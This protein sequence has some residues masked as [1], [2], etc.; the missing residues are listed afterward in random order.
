MNAKNPVAGA[1]AE[2]AAHLADRA[3]SGSSGLNRVQIPAFIL[4][5]LEESLQSGET[6][7]TVRPGMPELRERIA[8]EI[9]LSGGPGYDSIDSVLITN[10]DSESLFVTLLG[11]KLHEGEAVVAPDQIRQQPLLEFFDLRSRPATQPMAPTPNI[12][13]VYREREASP[14]VQEELAQFA[15]DQDVPDFLNLGDALASSHNLKIPP[16][17][18]RHTLLAGTL[19]ALPGIPVFR[20]GYLLGSE[21]YMS[22]IRI[23]KQALSICSAAPSQRAALT[24]LTWWQEKDK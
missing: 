15:Q 3:E 11:L 6:H 22:R 14:A 8:Q 13:L 18:A 17:S 1:I 2:R 10:G 7:Y 21:A 24:A 5:S 20:V 19:D 23:W 4:K 12:R 16:V 9:S